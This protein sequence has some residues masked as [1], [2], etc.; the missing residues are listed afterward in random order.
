RKLL[1]SERPKEA[2]NRFQ[3]GSFKVEPWGN[4]RSESD[5][6][7]HAQTHSPATTYFRINSTHKVVRAVLIPHQICPG[8]RAPIR[9]TRNENAPTLSLGTGC[10]ETPYQVVG[11]ASALPLARKCHRIQPQEVVETAVSAYCDARAIFCSANLP[12]YI[13]S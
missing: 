9:I 2:L 13:V 12:P 4:V 8:M 10:I 1:R 5:G 3:H 7:P 11:I 6:V